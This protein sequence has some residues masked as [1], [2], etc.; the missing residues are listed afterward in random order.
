MT[1]P[2]MAAE[3]IVAGILPDT[4]NGMKTSDQTEDVAH[5]K[6]SS[7]TYS[8]SLESDVLSGP[9]RSSSYPVEED[10]RGVV[11]KKFELEFCRDDHGGDC[12][13]SDGDVDMLHKSHHPNPFGVLGFHEIGVHG[14]DRHRYVVRAWVKDARL[15]RLRGISVDAAHDTF[16]PSATSPPIRNDHLLLSNCNEPITM[17]KRADWLFTATFRLQ[18][19]TKAPPPP[20]GHC[21]D[22]D[23][24][25]T[26]W[27]D[28][29]QSSFVYELLVKYEGDESESEFA[30]RDAYS[31]GEL[32]HHDDLQKFHTSSIWHVDDLMGSH[33]CIARGAQGTMFAV[34]SPNAVFVSVVGDWNG[35]DGRAHPMKKRTDVWELFVPTV[36]VPGMKY[37]YKIHTKQGMDICKFDPFAQV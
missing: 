12:L 20:P 5:P 27:K 3:I 24:S 37:A 32:L 34:W 31:Y 25:C 14:E 26:V 9:T 15:V 7:H 35:W 29:K 1:A 19:C 22:D 11:N 36:A 33:Y 30:V 21:K 17:H 23:D 2:T 18:Q 8:A 16:H 6:I 4:S 13:L 10:S 28:P